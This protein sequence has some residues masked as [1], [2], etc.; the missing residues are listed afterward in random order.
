MKKII[1]LTRNEVEDV[2]SVESATKIEVNEAVTNI[3]SQK[4]ILKNPR[5]E[6]SPTDKYQVIDTK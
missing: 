1:N 2:V 4:F 3:F 5:P 6:W